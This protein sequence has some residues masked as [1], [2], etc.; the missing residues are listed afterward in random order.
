MNVAIIPAR[1]GSKRIPKKNI[2][3]FAGRPIIAYSIAAARESGLF[4]RIIVSTD[5]DEIAA[6]AQHWGAEVPFRRPE[7]LASDVA[8]TAD[9]ILHALEWLKQDGGCDYACC[10]Y[11]TAPFLTPDFL[12][13]GFELMQQNEADVAISVVLYSYPIQRGLRMDR[14]GRVGMIVP[15]NYTIRSQDLPSSYHDAG[16]FYWVRADRFMAHPSLFLDQ[17]L[18]VLLPTKLVHDIDTNEDWE[19]AELIFRAL[20]INDSLLPDPA[21]DIPGTV[22]KVILGTAQLGFSYGIANRTGRP[23]ADAANTMLCTAWANG[24]RC[25]DTAQAYGDSEYVL[26]NFF[27][28]SYGFSDVRFI[29][30]LHPAINTADAFEIRQHVEESLRRLKVTCL[31]ALL[32]HREEHL[33]QWHGTLGHTLRALRRDGLVRHL[34]LSAYNPESANRAIEHPDLDIIEVAASVFDRRSKSADHSRL[35]HAAKK[36]LVVRSIFLQ[37][38][39]LLKPADVPVTIPS[40]VAAVATLREFCQQHGLDVREFAYDY[41]RASYPSAFLVMGSETPEQVAENCRLVHRAPINPRLIEAWDKAW[42][43]DD[44]VLVNPS[45]WPLILA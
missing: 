9:V 39:V 7:E 12:R 10:I 38:L 28:G 14:H 41:I 13:Q 42:P 11:P 37:G 5:C 30:K 17:P 43:T 20:H 36:F 2:R 21:A 27:A 29:S 23:D 34:G 25:F 6:V 35:A 31:W 16:Q 4:D 19:I 22:P 45:C 15:E 18:G 40:A 32:L 44:P 24:I 33:E 8:L 1:G 3:K 26:G